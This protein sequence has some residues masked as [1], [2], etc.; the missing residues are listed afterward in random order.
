MKKLTDDARIGPMNDPQTLYK[1]MILY[2]LK[3]VNF[4]LSHPQLW[5]FFEEKEYTNF[6]TFQETI[7]ALLDANLISRDEIRGT[8][9]YELTRE[10]DDALY[11][12]RS[13]ITPGA[14]ED[15]DDFLKANR[16]QLRNETGVTADYTRTEEHDY[17]TSMIVR[18][19]KSVIFH[20]QLTVPTEDQAR[21]LCRHFE[22]N[23]QTIYA[24]VM[25]Q[26]M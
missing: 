13:D 10:G 4:P 2:L 20:L 5:A 19:G 18:E 9:R 23:A 8:V 7:A 26:L 24:A 16:Y 25:K 22:E 3:A 1:L 14:V 21:T 6:F 15:M 12:F 17:R 11:Y